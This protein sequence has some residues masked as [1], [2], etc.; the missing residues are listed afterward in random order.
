METT[1]NN[2]VD[3]ITDKVKLAEKI[4]ETIGRIEKWIKENDYRVSGDLSKYKNITFSGKHVSH[5]KV[6]EINKRIFWMENKLTLRKVNSFFYTLSKAFELEKIH[7]RISKKEEEIQK[8]RKEWLKA[9]NE[10]DR[11]HQIY[12]A[13]KGD[14]YKRRMV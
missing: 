5:N 3:Y 6:K 4:N 7:V 14:F 1:V 11:L 12:I 9:R 2:R 8:A 10:A 13:E